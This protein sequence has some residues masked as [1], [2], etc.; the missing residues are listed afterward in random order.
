MGDAAAL[1]LAILT[2]ELPGYR[3]YFPAAPDTL[4]G[5]SASALI[6]RLYGNVPLRRPREQLRSLVDCGV[7]TQQTGWRPGTV[8]D[9]GY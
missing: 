2:S 9:P 4:T 6:E 8:D 5:E 7:I 1:I 3:C